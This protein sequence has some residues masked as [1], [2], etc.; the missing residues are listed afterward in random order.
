[1]RAPLL[2]LL[3]FS[4]PA[5]AIDLQGHRGARGLLPENTLPSFERAIALG[6]TTLE[7][8]VGVTKDGVVVVHHDRR[9]NPDLA[10][11]PDGQYVRAP[12]PTIHSL[13]FEELQRYDVGRLRPGWIK[14]HAPIDDGTQLA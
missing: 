1:M 5:M 2:A 6:V 7:M 8:D 3:L 11:G 13:G 4:L 9:L 12:A 14:R 10:R